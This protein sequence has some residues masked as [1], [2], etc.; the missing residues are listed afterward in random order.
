[1]YI[2]IAGPLFNNS[3]RELNNTIDIAVRNAGYSTYLPQRDGGESAKEMQKINSDTSLTQEEK[4]Q[5]L[6]KL[7]QDIFISDIKAIERSDMMIAVLDGRVPDEGT[8][9]EIGIAFERGIPIIGFKTDERSFIQGLDNIMIEHTCS[10]IVYSI[11]ELQQCL[12][13][14]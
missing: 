8:C 2:Y 12:T 11:E 7:R 9:V 1:M 6:Y 10:T 3:E 14:L 4:D 13:L 5:Q